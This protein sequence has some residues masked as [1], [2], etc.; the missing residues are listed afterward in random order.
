MRFARARWIPA[1][2]GVLLCGCATPQ[3]EVD[4]SRL[5]RALESPA[6]SAAGEAAPA[7]PDAPERPG[8]P[9]PLVG[10]G[11]AVAAGGGGGAEA[12]ALASRGELTIQPNT[13]LQIKVA[14]DPSLNGNYQVNS[15][16]A[17]NL[18]YVGPIILYNK[19]VAEARQK[20]EDVLKYR[21]FRKATVEVQIS[22]ASYDRVQI[23]GEVNRPG[24]ITIGPGDSISL[25]D[26]L[27]MAGG[28]KPV[29]RPVVTVIRGGLL[30]IAPYTLPG[31]DYTLLGP[32]GRLSI[33]AVQLR[34]NDIVRVAAAGAP[35]G[36]AAGGAAGAAAGAGASETKT[37]LV[38]GEVRQPGF[39]TFGPG[40]KCT[41]LHLV[42]KM[43][44]LPP[45]ANKKKVQIIRR[46][47]QGYE[48]EITVNVDRLLE[49]GSPD[50]DVPLQN[51]DRVRVPAK[52][53][54]LF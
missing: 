2:L 8:T 32:D 16:G 19:T 40:E 31:E 17:I 42:L 23:S 26:A 46:D 28:L 13:I 33:P 34:N 4:V 11:A 9:P 50:D 52:R 36:G 45:F 25:H 51:G 7:A 10:A 53:I 39:Y 49:H 21:D 44:G 43:G 6:P 41:M 12:G 29:S 27:F 20:I 54:S 14:E 5:L 38:L 1:L 37:I 3:R 47:A 22:R 15:L 30:S 24:V 48:D 35:G 18:G